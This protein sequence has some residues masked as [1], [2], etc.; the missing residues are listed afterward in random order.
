VETR[1]SESGGEGVSARGGGSEMEGEGI[2]GVE[3]R[4][5]GATARGGGPEGVGG[6]LGEGGPKQ[7]GLAVEGARSG[8]AQAQAEGLVADP[9]L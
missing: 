4:R 2:R 3:G 7:G 6:V 5:E 1:R 8:P 9:G